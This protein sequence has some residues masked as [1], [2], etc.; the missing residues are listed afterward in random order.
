MRS[1]LAR[2]PVRRRGQREEQRSETAGAV[3]ET[4][5]TDPEAAPC[6][7]FPVEQRALES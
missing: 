1:W 2:L 6:V 3:A 7:A 5:E 4:E